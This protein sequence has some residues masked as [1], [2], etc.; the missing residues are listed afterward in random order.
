MASGCH[1]VDELQI[2]D[3]GSRSLKKVKGNTLY[4]YFYCIWLLRLFSVVTTLLN[5]HAL[6]LKEENQLL[7]VVA[8]YLDCG[9]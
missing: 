7:N 4:L 5:P 3:L 1:K 8:C 6:H 9:S 2:R